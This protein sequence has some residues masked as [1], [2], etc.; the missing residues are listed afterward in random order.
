MGS[1]ALAGSEVTHLLLYLIKDKDLVLP[2]EPLRGVR[3]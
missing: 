1:D 2:N 3:L